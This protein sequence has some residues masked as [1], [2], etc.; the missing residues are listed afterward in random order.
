MDVDVTCSVCFF[1]VYE[2]ITLYIYVVAN[3]IKVVVRDNGFGSFLSE[4]NYCKI[5]REVSVR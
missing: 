5:Y 4:I 2:A 3:N 1:F